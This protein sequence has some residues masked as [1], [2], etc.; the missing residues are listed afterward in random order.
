MEIAEDSG[1]LQATLREVADRTRE[2]ASR[3][4]II[5]RR[6]VY[7]AAT[8]YALLFAGAAASYYIGFQEAR[9]DLGNMVQAIW[10]TSHGHLLEYTTPG[11]H[12]VSRLGS[13]VDPF[14][15]LLVP[16]WWIWSSPVMLLILQA[17]A[18]ASGV[19]P[20]YWLAR[21]HLSS[22]RAATHFAFAYLL[23]PAT[24]Y[25]AFTLGTG[26]H[27]VS[28]AVPLI[29][30]AIW[31]L[32]E[33]RLLPF[34]IVALLAA[35]TK[36]EIP[37]A[38]GCLGIWFAVRKGRRLAGAAIFCIGATVFLV[39]FLVIIPHF[40]RAG[41][42]PFADRYE[43]VG[44]SPGGML[45]TAVS[46]PI[47]FLTAISTW[48]KL[49]FVVILLLPF[50]G[51]WLLEPLLFLGAIPDLGINLLSSK[52]EQTTI[53]FHYTAGII[54]F[55]FAASILGAAKLKRDHDRIS[56]Y[57][58]AGAACL[59][60]Y[61]PIYFAAG[62]I[63]QALPSNATHAAKTRALDLI[64]AG[65]P[66]SASSRLAAYLSDR[67]QIYVFPVVR[68]ANWVVLEKG[69]STYG[70]EK[71]YRRVIAEIDASSHWTL[72][73]SAHGVQVLRRTGPR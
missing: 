8:V 27:S 73:Y 30:Y 66:V 11:G 25:N 44:G 67:R 18:V 29:L 19:L 49:I 2:N 60:L 37:L 28:L 13:H 57:A 53:Q 10:S 72:V 43:N 64:P 69:D 65:V 22:D 50:F 9:L 71:G 68:K 63:R 54:P 45:H 20:V 70:D 51:L 24:Q 38:V 14:L 56:F 61:S 52:P 17:V 4:A 1:A 35:S 47:A 16:L 55:L 33:E 46:D 62:D 40:A 15:V 36:E 7:S 26:F 31:F 59:A 5:S 23:Y 6:I 39:N 58:L 42:N 3:S 48:H 12:Q 32:D 41:L 21:K 34:A